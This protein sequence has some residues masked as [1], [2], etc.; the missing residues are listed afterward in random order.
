MLLEA[1]IHKPNGLVTIKKKIMLSH[2][3]CAC[4]SRRDY[5][6]GGQTEAICEIVCLLFRHLLFAQS[7]TQLL[8]RDYT[9]VAGHVVALRVQRVGLARVKVGSKATFALKTKGIKTANKVSYFW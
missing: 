1:S 9:D 8:E 6:E 4:S 2:R 3:G 7:Q 5:L